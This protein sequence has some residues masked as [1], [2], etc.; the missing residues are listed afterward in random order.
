M[1]PYNPRGEQRH[2]PIILQTLKYIG[3]ME[4]LENIVN[5]DG[6]DEVWEHL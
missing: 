2:Y 5:E 3:V 6:G 4:T 1:Y